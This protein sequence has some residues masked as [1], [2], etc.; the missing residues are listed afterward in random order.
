[1]NIY[2][3]DNFEVERNIKNSLEYKGIFEGA[4]EKIFFKGKVF[5]VSIEFADTKYTAAG[6]WVKVKVDFTDLMENPNCDM[7]DF[8]EYAYQNKDVSIEFPGDTEEEKNFN[9]KKLTGGDSSYMLP[10]YNS[11]VTNA[12]KYLFAT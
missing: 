6:M 5:E 7:Q 1:M 11:I 9:F 10:I 2:E 3:V 4:T 8:C 12:I